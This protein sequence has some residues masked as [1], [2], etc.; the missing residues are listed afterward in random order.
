MGAG[1]ITGNASY[2]IIKSNGTVSSFGTFA[3]ALAPHRI[4][5]ITI[6]DGD[7]V[8]CAGS[9]IK[10]HFS[11]DTLMIV[12]NNFTAQ[13]SDSSGSFAS[14]YQLGYI[15]SNR[16]DSIYG[17]VPGSFPAGNN[18]KL[19]ITGNS[20]PDTSI[21]KTVSIKPFPNSGIVV[22]GPTV[23]CYGGV[24][25]YWV[26]PAQPGITYNWSG[27]A[28]DTISSNFDTAYVRF[29]YAGYH[30]V[31]VTNANACRTG[32]Y[33]SL[34]VNVS[35][36]APTD[37]PLLNNTGRR[38]YASAPATNQHATGYHWYNDNI[39]I[40]G[41]TSD[42]Y[43][44]SAAGN[45]KV[46]YY[47]L[48][49]EG[50]A[51]NI[52]S[53]AAASIPQ[54]II[55]PAISNKTYGDAPFVPTATVTSG[56]PVSFFVTSGP[57]T[58]NAQTNLLT[59]TG[60]GLVTVRAN[61]VG[62]NVYD[63]A[64]PVTRS[65]TVN[66][67]TQVIT[68]TTIPNQD[69]SNGTVALNA[70]SNAALPISYSIVS[71]PATIAENMVTLTGVG[72]IMVRASQAGDTNYLP[73]ANVDRSFCASVTN[74]NA[75]MGYTNLCPGTATYTVNNIPG[76]TYLWR[77]AGGSTLPSTTNT[78]NVNWATPGIYS[79]IVSASGN[80]G[81]AS[82][83]DTLVVHVINSIEPDSVQNM[84]P[85]NNTINQ[86]LPLTLSWVPAHPVNFYTFDLYLW[87]ADLAQPKHALCCRFNICKLYHTG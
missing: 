71:G 72:T 59:V 60:T 79:L 26:T 48:C 74:L 16:S 69:I 4:P 36:P 39:L 64:A 54:T 53:F 84:L 6:A 49:N 45:Y 86:Q 50:P 80:C 52:I 7:S 76:A 73:A 33:T 77:I 82:N 56:L 40:S 23:A 31:A 28:G 47:N 61:Q 87:K 83:N 81:A 1:S 29:S 75:V 42:S 30:Y 85:V 12:N 67:A 57:A 21:A 62:D 3:L 35:Y 8:A 78:A 19:R 15:I 18:Y 66:K 22:Q 32:T 20:P 37:L 46:A 24:Y 9:N 68:F 13:L 34:S 63:T 5:V 14:P 43:Y 17:F 51:S 38:L 2:A 25:K 11:L 41:A 44:A 10:V 70:S 65:F 55:F 58:I 27:N